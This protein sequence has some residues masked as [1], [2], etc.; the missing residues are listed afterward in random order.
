M[1]NQEYYLKSLLENLRASTAVEIAG[2]ATSFEDATE[3]IEKNAFDILLTDLAIPRKKFVSSATSWFPEADKQPKTEIGLELIRFCSQARPEAKIVVLTVSNGCGYFLR[4]LRAGAHDYLVK[5]YVDNN[6]AQCLSIVQNGGR[7][8]LPANLKKM[9][10]QFE[11]DGSFLPFNLTD[12]ELEVLD[13]YSRGK[14]DKEI[15]SQFNNSPRT[16]R[17]IFEEHLREKMGVRERQEMVVLAV[18]EGLIDPHTSK[19]N[20]F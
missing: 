11:K 3:L 9:R 15:A 14:R 6:L 18:K 5:D 19:L 1:E 13:L 16:I 4:A 17:R 12:K 8:P 2:S 10:A 20:E 7:L